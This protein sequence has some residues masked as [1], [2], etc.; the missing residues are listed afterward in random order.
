MRNF[1]ARTART[2]WI[3]WSASAKVAT[4][5]CLGMGN[6]RSANPSLCPVAV[7]HSLDLPDRNHGQE[8]DEYQE[9]GEEK[10]E[11]PKQ[12][13][14]VDYRRIEH[15]PAGGEERTMYGN[16]DDHKPFEPH[17]DVHQDRNRK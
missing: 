1:P 5:N 11:R 9:A 8:T 10:A 3:S 15:A 13:A 6:L 14:E 2:A 16:N 4:R 12:D 7:C 17:S